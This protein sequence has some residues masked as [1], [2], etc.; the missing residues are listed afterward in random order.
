M[1]EMLKLWT[2][3]A[4]WAV[5]GLVVL[6]AVGLQIAL[7]FIGDDAAKPE[8]LPT[9]SREQ[10]R[11]QQ[12]RAVL[13]RGEPQLVA[14]IKSSMGDPDSFEMVDG[15]YVDGGDHITL[16]MTYR[17][18]NGFNALRLEKVGAAFDLQGNLISVQKVE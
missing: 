7:Y 4:F 5:V 1:I 8:P 11:E 9:L 3:R 13:N 12:I 2:I 6:F 17:G 14:H 16:V 10:I 18:R 15:R